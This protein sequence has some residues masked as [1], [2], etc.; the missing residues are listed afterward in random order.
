[1]GTVIAIAGKAVQ[2]PYH[3]HIKQ[4]FGAVLNHPLEIGA[5]VRFGRKGTVNVFLHYSHSVLLAILHA[6][7]DL[8]VNAFLPLSF[9]GITSVDYCV[10]IATS[11][12]VGFFRKHP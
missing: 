7:S 1:M 4:S 8:T 2:L 6:F 11:L 3:N 9:T 5:V 12:L 10:H